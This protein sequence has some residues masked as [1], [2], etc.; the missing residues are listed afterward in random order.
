MPSRLAVSGPAPRRPPSPRSRH[1]GT[2]QE[3]RRWRTVEAMRCEPLDGAVPRTEPLPAPGGRGRAAKRSDLSE[4]H[5]V[6]ERTR[7]AGREGTQRTRLKVLTPAGSGA[8]IPSSE[9]AQSRS[10][11]RKAASPRRVISGPPA[12]RRGNDGVHARVAD[13]AALAIG[14]HADRSQAQG[15]RVIHVPSSADHVTDHGVVCDGNQRTAP[16]ARTVWRCAL[17]GRVAT[18]A[19]AVS[20]NGLLDGAQAALRAATSCASDVDNGAS[21]P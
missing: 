20:Q 14:Q 16:A 13:A 6:A 5:A 18:H 3:R 21:R 4:R 12:V 8:A 11:G 17:R 1:R 2:A 15:R 7:Q 10:A 9:A 19:R